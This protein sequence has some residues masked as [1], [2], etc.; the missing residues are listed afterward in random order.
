MTFAK[1]IK[2]FGVDHNPSYTV[3]DCETSAV[4][5]GKQWLSLPRS[6]S[7][8]PTPRIEYI[9]CTSSLGIDPAVVHRSDPRFTELHADIRSLSGRLIVGHNISF[10]YQHLRPVLWTM[11]WDTMIADYVLSSQTKRFTPLGEL[12]QREAGLPPKKDLIVEYMDKGIAPQDIPPKEMVP[13]AS[14]DVTGTQEVFLSQYKRAS[15]AQRRLI[16][17]LSVASLA[18]ADCSANG[19]LL[20]RA[21]SVD[22]R[23]RCFFETD[24]MATGFMEVWGAGNPGMHHDIALL[25]GACVRK[26]HAPSHWATTPTAMSS[27]F[28]NKPSAFIA[29]TVPAPELGAR[30]IREVVL[31]SPLKDVTPPYAPAPTKSRPILSTA[32]DVLTQIH[33]MGIEPHASLALMEQRRRENHKLGTTYY[34]AL[35]EQADLYNGRIHPT[36]HSAATIT[37]RTSSSNPNIQNQPP[38]TREV[39]V[40]D[41]DTIFMEFDFQQLE[42]W[43]LAVVSG[44]RALMAA[45]ESG[46][47]VHFLTGVEAGMWK[48]PG[49]MTK[50]GRKLVKRINFGL[51]YGGSAPGLAKQS[52][53]AVNKVRKIINGF[54]TRFPGVKSYHDGLINWARGAAVPP[55]SSML[56]KREP[57]V[58]LGPSGTVS[59][60]DIHTTTGRSYR[61]ECEDDKGGL[62]P[63]KLKNYPIQGFGTGDFVPL[64]L[65]C[66]WLKIGSNKWRAVIHDAA[67]LAVN[68]LSR[69]VIEALVQDAVGEAKEI[70]QSL[71][72][73]RAATQLNV[74]FEYKDRWSPMEDDETLAPPL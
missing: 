13:Y 53:T 44:C 10:D 27:L 70:A 35:L 6:I 33:E 71:W 68:P 64:V 39:F 46:D 57:V 55:P 67:L 56:V 32:D 73:G 7:G 66:L 37:G 24:R 40:A 42:M 41:P 45:L 62:S 50:E 9:A 52:K 18:Y 49:E 58:E 47:D 15:I 11:V 14:Y 51:I 3:V 36:I 61:F 1:L 34:Q 26:G 74:S 5:V 20:D 43:A 72:T 22:R 16:L 65:A 2:E 30:R 69:H 21:A 8:H 28:F 29:G 17:I 38:E 23:D 4:L 12:M 31:E 63:T 48:N 25:K 60:V 59:S 19:L 54:Y